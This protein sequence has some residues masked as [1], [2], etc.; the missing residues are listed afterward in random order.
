MNRHIFLSVTQHH[1]L[2]HVA[3]TSAQNT[4]RAKP[5]MVHHKAGTRLAIAQLQFVIE[6]KAATRA[7][8]P[9]GPFM[10]RV[11]VIENRKG[12]LDDVL[13]RRRQKRR[14]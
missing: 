8:R 13:Y 9:G 1:N 7:P 6:A 12:L 14:L 4:L 11:M 3:I 5:A 2:V 10:Q